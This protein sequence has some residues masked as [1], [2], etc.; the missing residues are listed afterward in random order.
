[1]PRSPRTR[2]A[3]AAWAGMGRPENRLVVTAVLRLSGVLD[4]DDLRRRV[5][6]RLLAAHPRL[7][8][9]ARPGAVPLLPP[10]WRR[11][12]QVDLRHHV[13]EADG[14]REHDDDALQ[15]VAAAL[16]SRPLDPDRP[17][18]QL[19]LVRRTGSRSAV[20]ARFHHS[21]ADGMALASVLLRLADGPGPDEEPP[22]PGRP[23]A[24]RRAAAGVRA[25]GAAT[26][27]LARMLLGPAEPAT[28]LRGRLGTSK[29]LALSGPHDL[30]DV[31]VVARANGVSINDV[32]LAATA[33][34]LRSHLLERGGPVADLRVL[35][36]VDLRAGAPVPPDLGNLFGVGVVRLP[37]GEPDPARRLRAVAAGTARLAA[38][39]QAGG[40][41]LLLRLVGLLPRVLGPPA[42]AVLGRGSSAVVTNVP[43][44]RTALAIG[45]CRLEDV[46]FWVPTVGRIGLGISLFSYAGRLTVGVAVDTRLEL[47]AAALAQAVDDEIGSLRT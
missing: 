18:W 17:P 29:A 44:P 8:E 32:L 11:V 14:A 20:V 2:T 41:Y 24:P 1:V 37:V 25:A 30:E 45:P 23:A 12:D 28:L 10:L 13:V 3:D 42:V 46:A 34:G 7:G 33:G 16:V 38:S 21:L 31:R 40:T 15:R 6:E 4:V 43:G 9:V 5:Q 39:S 27:T 26:T 47:D 22:R 19:H 35:V 36:P